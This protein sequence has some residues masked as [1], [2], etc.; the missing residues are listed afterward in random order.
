MG[1]KAGEKT[2]NIKKPD[3]VPVKKSDRIAERNRRRQR[4]PSPVISEVFEGESTVDEV[5]EDDDKEPEEREESQEDDC[6]ED[7]VASRRNRGKR[8]VRYVRWN[9]KPRRVSGFCSCPK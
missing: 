3:S 6:N 1:R 7:H 4:T 2:S 5:S 8:P 9:I